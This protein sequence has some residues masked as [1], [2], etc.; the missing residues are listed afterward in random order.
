MPFVDLKHCRLHYRLDGPSNAPLLVLSHSL[1]TNLSV[2]DAQIPAFTRSFC[3]LRYDSRGHGR[4]SLSSEP[5]TIAVLAE[6][7]IALTSELGIHH[8]SFCGI[9]IG[10]VTGMVLSLKHPERLQALVLANTAARVATVES[11]NARIEA[12][13]THGI[14]SIVGATMER[15]FTPEFRSRHSIDPFR[16]GLA[17]TAIEGYIQCCAALRDADLSQS[18]SKISVP[19]LVIAG[20]HD[21][22]TTTADARFLVE[23]IRGAE[24]VELAA[25]HIS[26]VEAADEFSQVVLSFLLRQQSSSKGMAVRRAVLG[27]AHVDRTL[28]QLNDFNREFQDLITRYAWGEIWTRPGLPRH[29]RSLV[30]LAIMVALNRAEDFRMH[31]RAALNNGVTREEI[32][33]LLLQSAVYCGVPTANSAFHAAQEVFAQIEQSENREV[34]A[35]DNKDECG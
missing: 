11:W 30:T 14:E 22:A 28:A 8:F 5:T 7:V 18:M 29:A 3:V 32:K 17:N 10:G 27:D 33:E 21:Q 26:N 9:S 15:W 13:Q 20:A 25:A 6:D 4:S 35:R 2:W 34:V 31:V 12:V 1:G 24:Y 19:T 16:D 23:T